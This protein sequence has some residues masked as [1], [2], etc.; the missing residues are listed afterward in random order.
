MPP[1]NW[2]A[3]IVSTVAAFILGGLWYGPFFS[4]PWMR[5][6]G[7]G[8]DFKPRVSRSVL[9]G[10]AITFNFIAALVFAAF[11]GPAPSLQ[12]AMGVGMAVGLAWV[13]PCLLVV[14]LFAARSMI[15]AAIDAG[16]AATQFVLY[17]AVFYGVG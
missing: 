16:F 5:E 6:M 1:I 10:L 2:L 4:K 13:A 11:V 3:V 12:R 7:V 14:Y 15:L 9:F 8:R 17:G